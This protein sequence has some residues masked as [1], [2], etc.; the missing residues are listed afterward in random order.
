[1]LRN[2]ADLLPDAVRAAVRGTPAACHGL[3][4]EFRPRVRYREPPE[5]QQASAIGVLVAVSGEVL[6]AAREAAGLSLSALARRTTYAKGYLGQLETGKR[7]V[8][9]EHVRAYEVALGL[10]VDVMA[11]RFRPT[12]SVTPADVSAALAE[13]RVVE[14]VSGARGLSLARSCFGNVPPSWHTHPEAR[15][16]LKRSRSLA[17]SSST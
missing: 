2:T 5:R 7:R 17:T 4:C 10:S 3:Y 6:R 13:A 11:S 15:R 12:T 9:E 16:C 8:L 14:E 1:M